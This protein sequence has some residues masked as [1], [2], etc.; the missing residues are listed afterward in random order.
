MIICEVVGHVWA[1]KKMQALEGQKLMIVRE[2]K[3]GCSSGVFVAADQVGA[4]IGERVLV[5]SGSTAR[6]A[7]GGNDLPVDC[8]IVGI[9]DSFEMDEATR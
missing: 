2:S 8:A 6:L 3:A 9:I 5:V 1:T 7:S 4:G